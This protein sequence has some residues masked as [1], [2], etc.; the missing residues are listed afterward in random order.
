M[1]VLLVF[2]GCDILR[3]SFV[4]QVPTDGPLDA[5]FKLQRRLPAKFLLEFGAVNGITHIVAGTV[6]D[7]GDEV[8]VL[9]LGMAQQ[10]VDGVDNH[11]DDIDIFPLVETADVVC[12]G[13][14]ALVEDKV[15]GTGVVFNIQPVAHVLALAVDGQRFAVTDIVDEKRYQFLR[16]LIGAIVVGAIG[17]DGGQTIGVVEGAH[18]V[19]A[20]SL[21]G[22]VGAVGLVFQVLGEELFSVGQMV[23]PRRSFRC[24][25]RLDALGMRHLQRTVDLV[26]RDMVETFA[27]ELLSPSRPWRLAVGSVYPLR[28]SGRR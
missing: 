25:R 18:K 13:H 10:A 12:L 27:L 23:L 28:W 19:V 15:D 11:F 8:H 3:P 16:E 24:E 14:L 5:F 9:S 17:D 26:G 22:T 4:V 2:T 20:R 6:G 7:I 1:I 21:G